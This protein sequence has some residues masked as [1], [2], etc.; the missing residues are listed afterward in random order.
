M[1]PLRKEELVAGRKYLCAVRGGDDYVT[2][3]W[4]G[5]AFKE[6]ARYLESKFELYP[7]VYPLPSDV[8]RPTLED[9]KTFALECYG[10]ARLLDDPKERQEEL[11]DSVDTFA[12]KFY[13]KKK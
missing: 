2:R 4:D 7:A 3:E 12:D 5:R 13:E 9:V 10:I 8:R 11:K 6:D 1:R